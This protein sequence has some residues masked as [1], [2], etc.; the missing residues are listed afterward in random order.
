[1]LEISKMAVSR[2]LGFGQTGNRCIR[3]AVKLIGG[4]VSEISSSEVSKM[5][6][7]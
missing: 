5:V 3:S 4:H 6:E 7:V 1:M 2:H